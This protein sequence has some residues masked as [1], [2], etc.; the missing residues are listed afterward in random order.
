MQVVGTSVWEQRGLTEPYDVLIVGAGLVG[1]GAALA[2]RKRHLAARIGILEATWGPQNASTRNAGF[3][4]FGSAT[5][6]L[7]DLTHRPE[8]A[9]RQ[10]LADRWRGLE[11]LLSTL[12]PEAIGYQPVGGTELFT[13]PESYQRALA[14]LPQLNTWVEA[15]TGTPEAYQPATVNGYSCIHNRLEGSLETDRLMRALLERVRA[16]GAQLHFGA[17]V[18]EVYPGGVRLASGTEVAAPRVLLTTGAHTPH[19]FAGAPLTPG[20][21]TVLLSRPLPDLPWAGTWH[22]DAGYVYWRQVGDR[23]LLGGGRNHFRDAE[24]TWDTTPNPDVV[25]YLTDFGQRVLR[26]PQDWH[27]GTTWCGTLSFTP[28]RNPWIAQPQPGVWVAAGLNGMGVAIGLEVGRQ[29]VEHA[30]SA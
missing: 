4:C 29:L 26:L 15:L 9:V 16:Q 1:L 19:L 23:V 7:A 20:R 10:T 2:Y 24:R 28:D 17:S 21:A 30:L 5:E 11:L 6:L 25:A 8:A 13:D 18:A 14:A 22:Y 27:G 3:A 12:G